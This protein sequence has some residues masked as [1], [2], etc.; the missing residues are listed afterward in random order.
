[1]V[2]E[3]GNDIWGFQLGI[4]FGLGIWG[5][6]GKIGDPVKGFMGEVLCFLGIWVGVNLG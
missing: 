2:P 5:S 4:I 3:I 6:M 1:M